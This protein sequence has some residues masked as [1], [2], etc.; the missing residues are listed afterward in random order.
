[1][2]EF[3]IGDIHGAYLALEQVL[4]RTGFD[5]EFDRLICIGDVC[6][7]GGQER[8]CI[9][10]LA[11]IKNLVLVMGNHDYWTLKWL[12][13]EHLSREDMSDWLSQGG[14]TTVA[15]LKGDKP[16]CREF[17][18]R[19]VPYYEHEGS[20]FVHGGIRLDSKAEENDPEYMMWDRTML[21]TAVSNPSDARVVKQY[22]KVYCGHTPVTNFGYMEIMEFSNVTA[23]DTGAGL[24]YFLSLL[25]IR[26]GRIW[27]SDQVDSL[28]QERRFQRLE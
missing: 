7:R 15:S 5:K 11:G 20:L 27:M 26:T 18:T 21:L 23:L 17:L 1:M 16:F 25:E 9:H 13:G 14:N 4:N 12:S 19:A 28:Y 22:E 8:E 10:L 3:V 2:R 6:D 24:G